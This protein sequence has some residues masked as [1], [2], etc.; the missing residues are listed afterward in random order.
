MNEEKQR[1][2][3]A[4]LIVNL[5]SPRSTDLRDVRRYLNEFLMD[6][7]VLDMPSLLRLILVRGII[8]PRRSPKSQAA[9]RS[10]WWPEGSPLVVLTNRIRD[11]LQEQVTMPVEAAMRYGTPSLNEGFELLLQRTS[12]PLEEILVILLYPHYA[13]STYQ[14]AMEATKR[15]AASL[16][17]AGA[18]RFLEPYYQDSLYIKA[19]VASARPYLEKGYDHLLFSYHGLPEHH[20]RK[21]DPTGS[22]CLAH[23]NCCSTPSPAHATCYRA[24]VLKTTA[25]FVAEAGIPEEQYSV[26]FQSRLGR[27]P[28]LKPFTDLEIAC[29]ATEGVKRLLV[30]C[31]SFVTDCL[32]T[33]EEIGLRGRT[34]FLEAG[35]AEFKLI[36]CLNDHPRWIDALATWCGS[37]NRFRSGT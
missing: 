25:A 13:M 35:G 22:H 21:T 18:L 23:E 15:A 28:W 5:G 14:T 16:G 30:I 4:V 19:L 6:P 10:I 3:R 33:L 1:P 24:H 29:L 11:R 7:F 37:T 27:A 9:Y 17:I 2:Q 26:A 20:L 31:P 8:V 36:P 32:E 12:Q 34:L